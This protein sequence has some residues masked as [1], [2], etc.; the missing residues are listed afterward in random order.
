[1]Q[2]RFD[3]DGPSLRA[4]RRRISGQNHATSPTLRDVCAATGRVLVA[5]KRGA[6]PHTDDGV[7]VRRVFHQ[8]RSH[9]IENFNSQ[10]KGIFDCGSH[11]PTKGLIATQRF[12]LGT[13]LVYQLALLHRH[14]TGGDLRLGLK[15][16][17]QAA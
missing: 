3:Q 4:P 13:V 6:Y 14:E 12:A 1:M 17:L 9:A 2:K 5:T 16:L 8:L 15:P 10:F 11:V 7:E